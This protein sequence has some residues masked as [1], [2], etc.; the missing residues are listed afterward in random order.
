MKHR[1]SRL[2]Y[3]SYLLVYKY[4]VLIDKVVNKRI[5][6]EIGIRI[7]LMIILMSVKWL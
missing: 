7:F 3:C 1:T 5:H 2:I 4:V 6:P